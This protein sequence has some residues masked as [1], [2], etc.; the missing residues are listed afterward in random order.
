MESLTLVATAKQRVKKEELHQS[1][2]K[3]ATVYCFKDNNKNEL[4]T[5]NKDS[6]YTTACTCKTGVVS[7]DRRMDEKVKTDIFYF[8]CCRKNL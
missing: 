6:Q 5:V 8:F 4:Y 1:Q 2:R 7:Y 3:V